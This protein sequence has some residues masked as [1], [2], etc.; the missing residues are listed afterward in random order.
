MTYIRHKST[1]FAKKKDINMREF[2]TKFGTKMDFKKEKKL[3]NK[4]V[5]KLEEF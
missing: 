3:E 4:N 2:K 1:N 5:T